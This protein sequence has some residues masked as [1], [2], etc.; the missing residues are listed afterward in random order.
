MFCSRSRPPTVGCICKRAVTSWQTQRANA[1]D[2]LMVAV[3]LVLVT[4]VFLVH[5]VIDNL[6]TKKST[7]VEIVTRSDCQWTSETDLIDH[8]ADI[9][10]I[11]YKQSLKTKSEFV[12]SGRSMNR[13]GWT[14]FSCLVFAFFSRVLL[15]LRLFEV[16]D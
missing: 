1:R 6:S 16:G 5:V 12:P 4:G 15:R 8:L 2:K 13:N 14:A 3:P 9:F 11:Q 7:S 10:G